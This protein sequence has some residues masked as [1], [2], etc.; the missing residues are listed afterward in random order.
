MRL[1]IKNFVQ[2]QTCISW[3]GANQGVFNYLEALQL[4]MRL[5]SV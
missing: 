5:I 3:L 2:V 1:S 4:K